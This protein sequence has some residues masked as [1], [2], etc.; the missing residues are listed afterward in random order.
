MYNNLMPPGRRNYTHSDSPNHNKEHT[1]NCL[2]RVPQ[3]LTAEMTE[4]RRHQ[5]RAHLAHVGAASLT[6]GKLE[7]HGPVTC[8]VHNVAY[9]LRYR[10]RGPLLGDCGLTWPRKR[11]LVFRSFVAWIR[12]SGHSCLPGREKEKRQRP[13]TTVSQFLR[14]ISRLVVGLKTVLRGVVTA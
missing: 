2:T 14:P 8:G 5:I 4:G 12:R 13:G 6:D 7:T 11:R 9:L 10:S 3:F 1:N